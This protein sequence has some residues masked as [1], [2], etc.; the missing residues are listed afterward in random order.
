MVDQDVLRRNNVSTFGAEARPIMFAHGFG[1]DQL[2]WRLVTPVV[3]HDHQVV[4][5]DFVGAGNSRRD[6]YS[7]T[8]YN[9]LG[10]YAQDVLDVCAAL[11]LSGITFIGHSISGMI[12]MLAA[13]R[14]PQRFA[15][16]IMIGSSP[17]YI[18]D[19]PDY[20]G[21][22]ERAEIEGLLD[23]MERN[24]DDWASFLAPLA[25]RNEDR[26]ELAGELMD[27][28]RANDASIMRQF[29]EVTFFSDNRRLLSQLA[30]PTLLLQAAD[31]MIV[32][33]QVADYLHRHIA[34]STMRQM[35]A[36]GHYPQLS[37]PEETR[38]LIREYLSAMEA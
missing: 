12:G 16:M 37:A 28:F 31:D 15:R 25:M 35:Q 3:A 33:P 29:A 24:Y 21:G 17:R 4:L 9:G 2:I 20:I 1:C 6:A 13:L 22:F 23:L 8:R 18:N 10:G 11:G 36:S 30:V 27:N 34:G 7:I 38:H 19:L 14:E 5:F 26:P 32:P